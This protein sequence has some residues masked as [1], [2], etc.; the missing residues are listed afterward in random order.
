MFSVAIAYVL[1]KAPYVFPIV[2]GR[3]PEQLLANVEALDIALTQEQ[4]DYLDTAKPVDLG[5]PNF[6]IVSIPVLRFRFEV[7]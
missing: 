6:L 2:G 4:I 5:F 1:H 3:K 7:S